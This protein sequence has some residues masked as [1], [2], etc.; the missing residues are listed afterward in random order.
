M[1]TDLQN[2]FTG[3]II[4]TAV[5]DALGAPFEGRRIPTGMTAK[6]L[7]AGFRDL[8]TYPKGQYT[9]DTQLTIV[10]AESIIAKRAIDGPD[11]TR[12]FSRLWE[13]GTII[14]AGGASSFAMREYLEGKKTWDQCGAPPGQAGNGTAMRAGPIGL[15]HFDETEMIPESATIASII[16]HRDRRAVA[17]A[18]VVASTVAYGITHPR[19]DPVE[20]IDI[21]HSVC[22][23][24]NEEFAAQIKNLGT[25]LGEDEEQAVQH[26]IDLGQIGSFKGSWNGRITAYVIPTVLIVLYYFLMHPDDFTTTL[27][28]VILTGGDVDT[29]GAIAGAISGAHNGFG[30]IPIRLA[31]GVK[32]ATALRELGQKLY[33]ITLEHRKKKS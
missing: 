14:G 11:I 15:W 28:K 30:D 9:D 3:C 16:T 1:I 20:L 25:W 19:V 32:D 22:S 33:E 26:I 8:P 21:L 13:R 4:G 6:E 7:L 12:R 23:D 2:K 17:G 27:S 29:T 10:L 24:I 18:A 31:S 5:G